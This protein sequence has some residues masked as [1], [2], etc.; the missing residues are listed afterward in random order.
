[1]AVSSSSDRRTRRRLGRKRNYLSWRLRRSKGLLQMSS[2]LSVR[3]VAVEVAPRLLELGKKLGVGRRVTAGSWGWRWQTDSH[4]VVHTSPLAH[5][6]WPRQVE[7]SY[8]GP[9][10][11]VGDGS[12][13]RKSWA[14]SQWIR[15]LEEV[16]RPG[17]LGK[18]LAK[19]HTRF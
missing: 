10:P 1:L 17:L 2:R 15:A 7:D 19:C 14:T 12:K 6:P 3:W 13:P 9:T 18:M 4:P 16:L 8:P 11:H 5:S